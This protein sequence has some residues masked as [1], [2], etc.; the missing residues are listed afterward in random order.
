MSNLETLVLYV[1]VVAVIVI[2]PAVMLYGD[3][4]RWYGYME[5]RRNYAWLLKSQRESYDRRGK[6]LE[7]YRTIAHGLCD[8]IDDCVYCPFDTDK[9]H[10]KCLLGRMDEELGKRPASDMIAETNFKLAAAL[11]DEERRKR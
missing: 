11:A 1:T 6:I 5:C 10:E 7:Q 4:R 3:N 8:R 9:A 2:P